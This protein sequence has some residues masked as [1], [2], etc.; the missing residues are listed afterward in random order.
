M[1]QNSQHNGFKEIDQSSI[2]KGRRNIRA[3]VSDDLLAEGTQIA[4]EQEQER[5]I[6]LKKKKKNEESLSQSF[7]SQSDDGVIFVLDA[8]ETGKS[9]IEIHPK[10]GRRLKAHQLEGVQFMWDSCYE[11]V[12]RLKADQGSGCILAHCMGLGKTFQV[13][14]SSSS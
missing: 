10:I 13:R 14:L 9:L 11:S 2:K 6:R 8:D 1:S 4:R 5:I 12:S 3:L 7:A